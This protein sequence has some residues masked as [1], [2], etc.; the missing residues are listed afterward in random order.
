MKKIE[1]RINAVLAEKSAIE[2]KLQRMEA[3]YKAEIEALKAVR[4][5]AKCRAESTGLLLQSLRG[6]R[7]SLRMD[8]LSACFP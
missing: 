8:S 5:M 1:A 2:S 6:R 7:Q 3:S 4:R